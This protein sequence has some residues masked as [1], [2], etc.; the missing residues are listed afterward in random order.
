MAAI[1]IRDLRKITG[2]AISALPGLTT[3]KAD[4]RTIGFLTPV[5]RPD[6]ERLNAMPHFR[7]FADPVDWDKLPR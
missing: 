2:K 4:G 5:R 6:P 1:D 3:I 7:G